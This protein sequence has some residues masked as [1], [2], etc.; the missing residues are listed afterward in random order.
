MSIIISGDMNMKKTQAICSIMDGSLG[1]RKIKQLEKMVESTYQYHF[2]SSHKITLFW[3]SV[4]YEQAYLAGELSTASTLQVPVENGVSNERRH[5]F[6]SEICSKWQQISGCSKNEIIFVC[7]DASAFKEFQ[8]AMSVRFGKRKAF[9][10]AR[11]MLQ[12]VVGRLR[13]GYF[14]TSVNI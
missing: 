6:M 13:N 8:D 14:S 7:P 4:P 10:K 3:I 2:G 11:I 5:R 1:Y 12:L 9:T